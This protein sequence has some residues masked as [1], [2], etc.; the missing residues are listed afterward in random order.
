MLNLKQNELNH[1]YK[2]LINLPL[3][4]MLRYSYFFASVL[5]L[6]S[7]SKKQQTIKPEIKTIT[8]AVYA[9][10]IIKSANQYEVF[11]TVTGIIKEIYVNE[12][13]TVTAGQPLMLVENE[14]TKIMKSNAAIIAEN[15]GLKANADK[16]E[17]LKLNME[18]AYQ[19]LKNDSLLFERQKELFANQI[20]SKTEFEQKQLNYQN[21]KT[22]YKNAVLRYNDFK[23]QTDL[24]EKQALNNLLLSKKQENDFIIKSLETGKVYNISKNKGELVNPQM[25]VAV[26]GSSNNFIVELQIDEYDITKIKTGLKVYLT[27]DSYKGEV[28]EG[29]IDKIY[30]IMNEKTKSFKVEAVFTKR[31]EMLYPNL[32]TEANI[33]I[34]QRKNV[35]T[36]PRKYIA[37]NNKVK[38]LNGIWVDVKTGIKD[39]EY[40]E[41]IS[42]INDND[43]LV[44]PK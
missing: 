15:A 25:P 41:I 29:L 5:L 10:G 8:E 34:T 43:E 1:T 44:E 39:L 23:R 37:E 17:E 42:G 31:P 33:I 32:T 2:S 21:A 12:G 11:S 14:A 35:L 30:P 26:I 20:G 19:K 7:C 40:I 6:L 18:F 22:A 28:Y 16:L 24:T 36:I 9:S 4:L 38:L 3:L 13:D 27:L